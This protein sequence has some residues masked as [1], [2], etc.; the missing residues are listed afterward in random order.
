MFLS[1]AYCWQGQRVRKV[2][3][4]TH[5]NMKLENAG[6]RVRVRTRTFAFPHVAPRGYLCSFLHDMLYV[7]D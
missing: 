4:T 2:E 1:E 7:Q 5:I 3:R 6:R